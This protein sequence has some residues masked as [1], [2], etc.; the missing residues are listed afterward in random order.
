MSADFMS[1]ESHTRRPSSTKST[2]DDDPH[3]RRTQRELASMISDLN[4]VRMQLDAL[5][6]RVATDVGEPG[7]T[8]E[9]AALRSRELERFRFQVADRFDRLR[10]KLVLRLPSLK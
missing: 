1:A 2:I 6:R 8:P 3:I 10:E 9:H 4:E 7:Q 5:I